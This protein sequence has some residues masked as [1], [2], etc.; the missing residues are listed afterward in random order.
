MFA[1]AIQQKLKKQ[2]ELNANNT[3]KRNLDMEARRT[4]AMTQRFIAEI[5]GEKAMYKFIKQYISDYK[6]SK[7]KK[8]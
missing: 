7:I 8:K 5:G 6:K 4:L 1:I 2:L 3:E